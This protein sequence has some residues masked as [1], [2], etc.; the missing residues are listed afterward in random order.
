MCL[1]VHHFLL[2]KGGYLKT[3]F[4]VFASA[5]YDI[6]GLQDVFENISSLSFL[7]QMF[8]CKTFSV[9]TWR[10]SSVGTLFAFE[11][12]PLKPLG[13]IFPLLEILFK[14]C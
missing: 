12:S 8:L 10:L 7:L 13:Q 5:F 9:I 1:P 2:L 3:F 4:H 6:V 14:Y 11:S